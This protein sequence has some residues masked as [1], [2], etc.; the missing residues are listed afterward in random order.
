MHPG[1]LGPPSM[2]PGPPPLSP[3]PPLA[4]PAHGYGLGHEGSMVPGYHD[5]RS[6]PPYPPP[7][8]AAFRPG[9]GPFPPGAPG[10]EGCKFG[11]GGSRFNR[12]GFGT[13]LRSAYVFQILRKERLEQCEQACIESREYPCRSFNFRVFSAENCELSQY[14]S[15]TLPIDN[16]AYFEQSTQYDYYERESQTDCLEV[17]QTCTPDGME[18][19]L[20]SDGFYGRIYTYGFYDSCFFDGNGGSVSVL[21]ISRPNG[22][23]RCGTQQYGDA[24]T[25]IV[26]VQFN[27]WVQ[28]SRDKKYN[29]TCYFSGPGEAVVTSSYMDTKVDG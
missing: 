11:T 8:P 6:K 12:I 14:D 16:Q 24:M 19:T 4:P 23:P 9:Y 28:T 29:L 27:D 2:G 22:F 18:F 21:R 25:N 20:K 13:R 3:G 15:K 26:V 17:S 10:S 5:Y 1:A 7:P